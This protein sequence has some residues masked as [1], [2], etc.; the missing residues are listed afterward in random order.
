MIKSLG[1][2]PEAST[3]RPP[4]AGGPDAAQSSYAAQPTSSSS[5]LIHALGQL[6]ARSRAVV[7][8]WSTVVGK[9]GSVPGAQAMVRSQ[10][11]SSISRGAAETAAA[12]A[13]GGSGIS[14][15][16]EGKATAAPSSGLGVSVEVAG[17]ASE[18]RSPPP[19]RVASAAAGSAGGPQS[20]PNQKFGNA[21]FDKSFD[22]DEGVGSSEDE[23]PLTRDQIQDM[24]MARGTAGESLGASS[25]GAL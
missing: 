12:A 20:Q 16:S 14:Q 23:A 6:E 19:R 21:L 15:P 3:G 10:A 9:A 2:Q 11:A 1:C 22:D 5:A 24:R 13:V 17:F 8:V 7:A 4:T 25:L 18:P